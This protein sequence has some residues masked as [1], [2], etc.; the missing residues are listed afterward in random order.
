MTVHVN[1]LGWSTLGGENFQK[2]GGKFKMVDVVE[3]IACVVCTLLIVTD[4]VTCPLCGSRQ[5]R[6]RKVIDLSGSSSPD[7]TVI[8]RSKGKRKHT[9]AKRKSK[10]KKKRRPRAKKHKLVLFMSI[11]KMSIATLT[12][13]KPFHETVCNNLRA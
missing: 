12:V 10:T 5:P 3:M 2:S 9:S 4:S 11:N 1:V 8:K 13:T 7:E 6:K